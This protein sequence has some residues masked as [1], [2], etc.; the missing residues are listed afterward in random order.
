MNI[1]DAAD[2]L[3]TSWSK[4]RHLPNLPLDCRPPSRADGYAERAEWPDRLGRERADW[5][6]AATS[7]A[8]QRH[9][10]VSG[11]LVLLCHKSRFALALPQQGHWPRRAIS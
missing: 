5:N 2:L 8:G 7:V 10:R 3:C 9:I 11:P 4:G 1:S 6:I